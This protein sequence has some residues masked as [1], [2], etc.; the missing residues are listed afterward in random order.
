MGLT[1]D[2]KLATGELSS[3]DW[4]G[5]HRVIAVLLVLNSKFLLGKVLH[6]DV[7]ISS[8]SVIFLCIIEE[9]KMIPL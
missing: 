6:Q 9:H 1:G 4:T 5:L 3:V 7:L 2:T 8:T